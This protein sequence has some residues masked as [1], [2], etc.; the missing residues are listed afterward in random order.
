[1]ALRSRL[2]RGIAALEACLV[3]DRAHVT[4]G[5]RGEH[6]KLI[7][8]ALVILGDKSIP[9]KEYIDG[10]Y[11]KITADVVLSYKKKRNIINRQYQSVPDNIVGKMTI[12]SLD[13][14][15]L[16][17]QDRLVHTSSLVAGRP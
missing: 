12:H 13:N 16:A 7:Q 8:R 4:L 11:G 6:V 3:D 2:L 14:D 1:M 17:V 9:G 10:V 15:L 5:T